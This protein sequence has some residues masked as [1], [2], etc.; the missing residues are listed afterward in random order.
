MKLAI[1][2]FGL[3]VCAWAIYYHLRNQPALDRSAARIRWVG[4]AASAALHFLVLFIFKAM[5]RPWVH[6]HMPVLVVCSAIPSFS[7]FCFLLCR[8]FRG[9]SREIGRAESLKNDA[10]FSSRRRL[11]F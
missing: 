7:F 8:D 6:Q 3:S 9:S 11:I 4:V 10:T 2:L 5:P 1:E